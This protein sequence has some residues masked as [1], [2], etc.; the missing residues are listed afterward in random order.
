M[1][2]SGDKPTRELLDFYLEAGADALLG[3]TPVDRFAP[4]PAATPA[5]AQSPLTLSLIHI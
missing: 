2:P 1:M 5:R 4:E 3:E